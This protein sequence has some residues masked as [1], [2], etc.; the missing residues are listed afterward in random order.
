MTKECTAIS[1][2]TEGHNGTGCS[3]QSHHAGRTGP[4]TTTIGASGHQDRTRVGAANVG[5]CSARPGDLAGEVPGAAGSR[6]GRSRVSAEDL[7][8][9]T[10]QIEQMLVRRG[11]PFLLEHP[12]RSIITD[13]TRLVK[14]ILIVSGILFFVFISAYSDPSFLGSAFDP[15]SFALGTTALVALLFFEWWALGPTLRS[16]VRM[17]NTLPLMFTFLTLYFFTADAWHV[18]GGM[19]WWRLIAF[20]CVCIA[21]VF[22]LLYRH[23]GHTISDT[24]RDSRDDPAKFEMAALRMLPDVSSPLPNRLDLPRSGQAGRNLRSVVTILFARRI[25]MGGLLVSFVLFALGMILIDHR[26]TLSLL[27][28]QSP[29]AAGWSRTPGFPGHG[30][31]VS[32]ALA[33]VALSLGG[34][35]AAYFVLIVITTEPGLADA[36]YETT[37]VQDISALWSLYKG[38]V[39]SAA[40]ANED[41]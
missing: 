41:N 11:L 27:G 37:F 24:D 40:P 25:L 19:D 3:E 12:V 36:T 5:H 10:P 38:L 26:E 35:A 14:I 34:L 9:S 21:V 2:D 7:S 4:L 32:E 13:I 23:A 33:K 31:F 17:G 18:F 16:W 22:P 29:T 20:V 28:A 15:S 8:Q 1:A 6:G 30:F 39:T